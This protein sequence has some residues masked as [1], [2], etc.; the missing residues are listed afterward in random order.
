MKLYEYYTLATA[1]DAFAFGSYLLSEVK[2]EK[3]IQGGKID[4]VWTP[5]APDKEVYSAA[6]IRLINKRAQEVKS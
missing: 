1:D 4:W 6:E 5:T 3:S 2:H